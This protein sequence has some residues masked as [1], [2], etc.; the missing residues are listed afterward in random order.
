MSKKTIPLKD[1][2]KSAI[3][4]NLTPAMKKKKKKRSRKSKTGFLN[5]RRA[6]CDGCQQGFI[7]QYKYLD[8]NEKK[9]FSSV[10]FL[11]LREK[12]KK[13]G[14]EWG[15]NDFYYARKTATEVGLPLSDLK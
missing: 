5:V 8:K 2:F 4:K 1:L 6:R 3:K 13:R 9:S 7:Y 15:I 12:A 14:Y 10:N 11:T